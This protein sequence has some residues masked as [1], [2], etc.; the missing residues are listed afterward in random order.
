MAVGGGW[1]TPA[2]CGRQLHS[3]CG[4]AGASPGRASEAED[5]GGGLRA[6]WERRGGT[7]ERDPTHGYEHGIDTKIFRSEQVAVNEVVTVGA[8]GSSLATALSHGP[9]AEAAVPSSSGSGAR[10]L[11]RLLPRSGQ[12]GGASTGDGRRITGVPGD[13]ESG[14]GRCW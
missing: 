14:P 9:L 6:V 8:D 12:W 5:G 1:G 13:R 7:I 3:K 4:T 2:P 10:G 11:W